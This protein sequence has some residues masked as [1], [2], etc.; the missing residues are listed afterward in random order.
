VTISDEE[1]D[2]V[3]KPTSTSSKKKKKV[4]VPLV[5]RPESEEPLEW[6]TYSNRVTDKKKRG[7]V[8]RL[9]PILF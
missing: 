6:V 7:Q 4:L 2:P 5:P 1:P 9:Y 8:C 3:P